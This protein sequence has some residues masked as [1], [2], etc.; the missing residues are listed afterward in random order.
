MFAVINNF[1]GIQILVASGKQKNYSNAFTVG[2]IAI[3]LSNL[4]LG[5]LY[6]INGVA[7]ASPI[8]EIILTISLI[9]Q[10]KK[11]ERSMYL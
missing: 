6:G 1:I 8:G 11:L 10:I 3:V 4:I 9:V 5:K 7:M 2:C